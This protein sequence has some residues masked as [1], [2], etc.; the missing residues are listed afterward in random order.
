MTFQ[1]HCCMRTAP[2]G[3][4]ACPSHFCKG[5]SSMSATLAPKP[6]RRLMLQ[7][8]LGGAAAAALCRFPFGAF[9]DEAAGDQIIPFLDPQPLE[10]GKAT[11]HWDELKDWITPMDQF[12]GVQHYGIPPGIAG[13]FSLEFTGLMGKPKSLSLEEIK[14][15]PRK[16]ITATLECSGN[17]ASNK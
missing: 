5:R 15:L 1:A 2:V 4:F 16:E 10:A 17:G 6:S 8:G 11:L 14:K 13:K 9:G 12:F 7:R 3:N